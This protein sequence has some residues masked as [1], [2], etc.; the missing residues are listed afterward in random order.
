[1]Q[2]PSPDVLCTCMLAR[3][4]PPWMRRSGSRT[5][6]IQRVPPAFLLTAVLAWWLSAYALAPLA[7]VAAAAGAIDVATLDRRLPNTRCERRAGP[8]DQCVQCHARPAGAL[9]R[10]DASVQRGAG[11]NCARRS[12]RFAAK[13]NSQCWPRRPPGPE[14]QID[15]PASSMRSTSSRGSSI[16][17][18]PSP[19]PSPGQ[20]RLA[21]ALGRPQ[22]PRPHPR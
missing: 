21:T 22:C 5:L 3:R 8:R 2:S 11:T 12:R 16:R 19:G 17:F 10:G 1:M 15:S 14:Q 7:R 20:I 18:S 13:S 9:G 4:S 6:L